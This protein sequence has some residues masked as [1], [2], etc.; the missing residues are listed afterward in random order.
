[1]GGSGAQVRS[2]IAALAAYMA[3]STAGACGRD[4]GGGLDAL[5]TQPH[6][7]AATEAG[8]SGMDQL[9]FP[10]S[11]ASGTQGNLVLLVA[12]A[13]GGECGTL[14]P[15]PAVSTITYGSGALI[16][17]LALTGTTCNPM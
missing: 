1:M 9:S 8:N 16:Q 4:G 15:S 17:L 2:A 14:A 13:I 7:E 10:A 11:V 5:D 6:F 12:V 3:A